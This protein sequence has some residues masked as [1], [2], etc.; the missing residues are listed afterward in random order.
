[1]TDSD[2]KIPQSNPSPDLRARNF[3]VRKT[4]SIQS[5]VIIID[6][7][8]VYLAIRRKTRRATESPEIFVRLS[9]S[10]FA[11]DFVRVLDEAWES[12]VPEA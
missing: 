8:D 2:P 1:L 4:N 5:S 7:R 12:A 6:R 11:Q 9:S 3:L 10:E